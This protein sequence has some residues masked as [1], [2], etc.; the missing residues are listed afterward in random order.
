MVQHL[1][2]INAIHILISLFLSYG[3]QQNQNFGQHQQFYFTKPRYEIFPYSTEDRTPVHHAYKAD[4]E[5][6][7][8]IT[9][10]Q[11]YEIK[12][13]PEEY[14]HAY[15]QN[16][17]RFP[18]QATRTQSHHHVH[19]PAQQE[20]VPVIVLKVP[21]PTKYAAHLRTLLQQY[22]E[23]R[24]AQVIRELQEQEAAAEH[25]HQQHMQQVQ[26]YHQQQHN[27]HIQ[28]HQLLAHQ[29]QGLQTQV[30]YATP[31]SV[32]SEQEAYYHQQKQYQHHY[33]IQA[34]HANIAHASRPH[35]Q[36]HAVYGI[37]STPAPAESDYLLGEYDPHGP[38]AQNVYED[39]RNHHYAQHQTQTEVGQQEYYGHEQEYQQQEQ[40][41]QQRHH[42]QQNQQYQQQEY[43]Q[44]G[45][46][47]YA[48][49]QEQQQQQH[50]EQGYVYQTP[51]SEI[52]HQASSAQS[53]SQEGGHQDEGQ[54]HLETP[55]NFPDEKHTRV[56]FTKNFAQQQDHHQ[57]GHHEQGQEHIHEEEHM[58]L[59][60]GN[61]HHHQL[62]I[63][64]PHHEDQDQEH[65]PYPERVYLPTP[66]PTQDEYGP[67]E[68]HQEHVEEVQ[69]HHNGQQIE[70][71]DQHQV[72]ATPGP[73]ITITQKR[74]MN[75]VPFNYHAHGRLSTPPPRKRETPYTE[76]QF[77]KFNKLVN[78]LKKKPA[79]PPSVMMMP[80]S[81]SERM[82]KSPLEQQSQKTH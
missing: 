12:E 46:I 13:V 22:L 36:G 60:G 7:V 66:V 27:H 74:K 57:H 4:G 55:E 73:F 6:T 31:A 16:F 2:I 54:S 75:R 49:E 33:G 82:K 61:S 1:T 43:H 76:E 48:E 30:Q 10:S 56:V 72:T 21:G 17:V 47:Q 63:Q 9:Q 39:L 24:A 25:Y 37:Q 14:P 41:H 20:E 79:V 71:Y 81:M 69:H 52:G 35:H 3:Y 34:A 32:N 42:H 78:K 64:Q 59:I 19:V 68:A 38:V 26:Q 15:R 44:Q 29:N 58:V 50:P 62:Q 5:T 65:N 28:H 18:G 11:G 23:I 51:S 45:H 67:T 77:N 8:E 40:D 70:D 80:M 53:N